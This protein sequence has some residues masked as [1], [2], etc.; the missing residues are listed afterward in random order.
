[1]DDNTFN[2]MIAITIA[3]QN[4][5]SFWTFAG[6]HPSA[7]KGTIGKCYI[8]SEIKVIIVA[9]GIWCDNQRSKCKRQIKNGKIQGN[10]QSDDMTI[11]RLN[12][13]GFK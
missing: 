7:S 8:L 4:E 5:M 11:A 1:V 10:L 9:L 12:E 13:M 2:H 3:E 6:G